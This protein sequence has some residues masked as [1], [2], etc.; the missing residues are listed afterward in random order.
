MKPA[1]FKYYAPTSVAEALEYVAQ[2]GYDGK[3][4][5]GGQSLVPAMNFRMAQPSALVDLNNIAELFYIHSTND[6]GVAIGTMTRDSSVEHDPLIKE[7]SPL[8]YEAMPN[9]AHPQIR[10]RGTFGG[11][12]AHADPAGQIPAL[13]IALDA[14]CRVRS[15]TKERWVAAEEFF[16]GPFTTALESDEML[17]EIVLP[18]LPK[19][20]GSC[21][22]HVARQ[23]GAT[24]LV[25][26][27]TVVTLD[28]K[29]LCQ[30]VHVVLSNVGETPLLARQAAQLL[31]GKTPKEEAIRAA[32]ETAS[33]HEIDPGSDIHASAQYRRY[34][35]NVLV[36]QT[37]T[38]AFERAR[39]RGG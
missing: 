23:R 19:R 37:L 34:L 15:K 13:V 20:S 25:G 35:A 8:I 2:L 3:V 12:V 39:H 28:E 10:N 9:I 17:V 1:P 29:G 31:V 24:S 27:S 18:P 14:K 22:Q 4:L 38:E 33:K 5:A 36:R 7:R 16:T 32:A 30:Q 26:V 6:S 21:Y 11:A